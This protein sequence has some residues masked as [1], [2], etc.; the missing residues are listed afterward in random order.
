MLFLIRPSR[1]FPVC[2]PGTYQCGNFEGHGTDWN[3]SLMG[4]RFSSDLPMRPG[5]RF[6]CCK[7]E[8][9]QKGTPCAEARTAFGN[10]QTGRYQV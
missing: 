9:A 8:Q 1:R 4:W 7:D 10:R 2:C 5:K 6:F 3:V